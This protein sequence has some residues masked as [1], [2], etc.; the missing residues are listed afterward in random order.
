MNPRLLPIAASLFAVSVWSVSF[1]A[2]K[3]AVLDGAPMACALIRFVMASAALLAVHTALGRSLA[4]PRECWRLVIYGA[5]TG[6]T[7]TFAFENLA[8]TYT[9]AGNSAMLQALSPMITAA[10]AWAFLRERLEARQWGGMGLAAA[11]T[12]AL[13]GPGVAVTGPGDALM[14]VVMVMGAI[15]GLCSKELAGRLPALTALTWMLVVGTIG[16]VPFV[17][18]EATMVGGWVPP[19]T[20]E[21][22]GALAYLGLVSSGVAYL[23]WQW[24]L[25]RL[26]VSTVGAFLY[27]MPLGTLAVGAA[28]LGEP[29]GWS[30]V[31]LAA[32]IL[33]GVYMAVEPSP[34]GPEKADP[35]PSPAP[36]LAGEG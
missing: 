10:G 23:A 15:Y 3:V 30:R 4:I 35:T 8:L 13:V 11:G 29:L 36:A 6:T 22:W 9:T 34:A 33:L 21:G 17:V 19:R 16:L 7:M 26:P 24:A 20:G 32:V 25:A 28:W 27:L 5:M 12:A 14:G 1:V 2:T 31:G 18:V